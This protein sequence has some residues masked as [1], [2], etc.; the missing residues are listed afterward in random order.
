MTDITRRGA[1]AL[2]AAAA[3]HAFPG[4]AMAQGR[5]F[6]VAS[7][8]GSWEVAFREILIPAFRA[9]NNNPDV[10][11]DALIGLDQIAKVT[12]SKGNP[13]LDTMLLDTGPALFAESQGLVEHFPAERSAHYNDINPKARTKDGMAPFFIFI[14]LAYN[15]DKIKTPPT[16]WNDLWKPEYKG[17]VGITSLNSTLGTGFLVEAARMRGGSEQNID[18]G[19]KALAELRPNL[20]SVAANPSQAAILFQQGQID[21]APAVF[22]EI[23]LLKSRDVPVDF[24]LPKEKGIG[25][26][27]TMYITKGSPFQDLAFKLIESALSPQVQEKMMREPFMITPTNAKVT[28]AGEVARVLGVDPARIADRLV[29]QDW[30]VINP[31]RSGWIEKFNRDIRL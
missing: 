6:A 18:E 19:F 11:L 17:R 2:L 4:V 22:N 10:A 7:I 12:A 1:T 8:T 20:A 30:G 28:F 13:P 5:R 3:V 16:S 29:F 21:I 15:T 27:S 31:Q 23:Q 9:A 24:V 14:G 25:Y 26:T